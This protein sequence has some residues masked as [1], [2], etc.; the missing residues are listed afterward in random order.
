MEELIGSGNTL[1][2]LAGI[3][4]IILALFL[5][6]K[7]ASCAAKIVIFAILMG[8]LGLVFYYSH[9]NGEDTPLNVLEDIELV[10]E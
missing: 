8:I 10:D 4:V 6:K 3:I 1:S 2:T 5:F 7:V 9:E